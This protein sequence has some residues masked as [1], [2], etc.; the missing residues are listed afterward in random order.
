MSIQPQRLVQRA[1]RHS[2]GAVVV[3][4][5]VGTVIALRVFAKPLIQHLWS[6]GRG[7]LR[8]FEEHEFHALLGLRA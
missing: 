7:E 1:S 4:C 2:T 8:C 5:L 3:L 6:S